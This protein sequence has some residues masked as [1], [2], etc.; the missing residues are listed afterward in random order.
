[1]LREALLEAGVSP[2][3]IDV[4][5]DEQEAIDAAL[6]RGKAGDLLLIFADALSRSWEQ[7]VRFRAEDGHPGPAGSG[8]AAGDHGGSAA[9]RAARTTGAGDSAAVPA[10][11]ESAGAAVA[12]DEG[13]ILIRDERGVRL[14]RETE[15]TD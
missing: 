9:G 15:V 14:A 1:M 2:Q 8:G 7:I 5:P 3:A 4:V 12:I 6:R 13:Q 11:V 10:F